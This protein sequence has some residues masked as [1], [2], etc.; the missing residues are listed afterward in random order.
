MSENTPRSELAF[1]LGRIQGDVKHILEAM[2]RN[3]E[4]F[5]A[6]EDKLQRA[7]E[8]MDKLEKFQVKMMTIVGIV[9]PVL[10]AVLT[11]GL[12]YFGG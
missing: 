3:Q 12:R 6:V 1:M 11:F 10:M 9:G 4:Q 2:T 7:D 8:R 5:K